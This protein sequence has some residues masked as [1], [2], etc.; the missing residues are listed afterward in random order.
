MDLNLPAQPVLSHCLVLYRFLSVLFCPYV[1]TGA[2]VTV[3]VTT[4]STLVT[5]GSLPPATATSQSELPIDRWLYASSAEAA[6]QSPSEM[7]GLFPLRMHRDRL[8]RIC[9][10]LPGH[11]GD[12]RLSRILYWLAA[13]PSRSYEC[14]VQ[15]SGVLRSTFRF[16]LKIKITYS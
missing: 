2:V 4:L 5:T 1:Q 16:A 10:G 6:W 3:C 12:S 9:A 7:V 8:S 11:H 13:R 15:I 14:W